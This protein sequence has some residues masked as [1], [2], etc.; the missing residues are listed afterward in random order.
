MG[1]LEAATLCCSTCTALLDDTLACGD[2]GAAGGAEL[3]SARGENIH[4]ALR[5][6]AALADAISSSAP[7]WAPA[8][9]EQYAGQL[10]VAVPQAAETAMRLVGRL[11]QHHTAV[12][13]SEQLCSVLCRLLQLGAELLRSEISMSMVSPGSEQAISAVAATAAKLALILSHDASL[14][15]L[16]YTTANGRCMVLVT[17]HVAHALRTAGQ[18]LASDP[19]RDPSRAAEVKR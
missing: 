3:W 12:G 16:V 8:P 19:P 17:W 15:K 7:H 4:T 6:A 13:W 9:S 2:S 11:L 10:S 5:G 14:C 1:C 18:S